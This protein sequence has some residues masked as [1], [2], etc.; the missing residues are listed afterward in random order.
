MQ[1]AL[2]QS[3]T[4]AMEQATWAW[5]EFSFTQEDA[6]STSQIMI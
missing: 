2:V 5:K 6:S 3:W 4:T 1:V